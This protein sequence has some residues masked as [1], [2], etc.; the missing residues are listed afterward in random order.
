MINAP[1]NRAWKYKKERQIKL[2][3]ET[4]KPTITVGEFDILFSVIGRTSTKLA[5]I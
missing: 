5:K 4:E 3:R 2:K 1:H